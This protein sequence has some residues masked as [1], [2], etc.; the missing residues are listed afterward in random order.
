[1]RGVTAAGRVTADG[2]D[3]ALNRTAVSDDLADDVVGEGAGSVSACGTVCTMA[4]ASETGL[5]GWHTDC[6]AWM[7]VGL[8]YE[9]V[10]GVCCTLRGVWTSSLVAVNVR[11]GFGGWFTSVTPEVDV[12]C[13]EGSTVKDNGG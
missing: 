2:I 9:P 4:M 1:M 3:G 5:G 13:V 11:T 10:G 7:V 6:T 12:G 8:A